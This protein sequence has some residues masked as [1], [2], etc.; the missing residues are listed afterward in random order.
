[1]PKVKNPNMAGQPVHVIDGLVEF[2]ADGVAT[3]TAE[4]A[5]HLAQIPFYEVLADTA[6]SLAAEGLEDKPADEKPKKA[7]KAATT[8]ADAE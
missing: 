7:K 5:A 8:T 1:M 6:Q 4:Q 2:D 3:V